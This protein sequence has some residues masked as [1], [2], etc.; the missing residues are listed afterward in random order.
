MVLLRLRKGL[1]TVY[2]DVTC[3]SVQIDAECVDINIEYRL[4]GSTK[5]MLVRLNPAS[6]YD[7]PQVTIHSTNPAT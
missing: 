4:P 7:G 3:Q 1:H 2:V 6:F 5:M